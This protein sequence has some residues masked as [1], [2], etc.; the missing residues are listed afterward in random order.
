MRSHLC[1]QQFFFFCAMLGWLSAR[2]RVC[3]CNQSIDQIIYKSFI[4]VKE[5]KMEANFDWSI[6]DRWPVTT[7]SPLHS[8]I[9]TVFLFFGWTRE[10]WW[11]TPPHLTEVHSTVVL[12]LPL[13]ADV[14]PFRWLIRYR[15]LH[16]GFIDAVSDRILTGLEQFDEADHHKV[17]RQMLWCNPCVLACDILH[18]GPGYVLYH[19]LLYTNIYSRVYS[20]LKKGYRKNT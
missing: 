12:P 13:Y 1:Q 18:V 3:V 4:K 16:A 2:A 9:S 7:L 14:R 8:C 10:H 5:R 11:G 20:L 17:V 19:L 6:I 15:P